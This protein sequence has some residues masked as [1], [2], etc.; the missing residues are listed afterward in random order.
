MGEALGLRRGGARPR[1]QLAAE[2]PARSQMKFVIEALGLTAG[3]GKQLALNLLAG[4]I[5]HEEHEFVLL[6]PN[7]PEYAVLS[8]PNLKRI[9]YEQPPSLGGRYLHLHWT[10]PR[11]CKEERADALLCLG[12]FTPRN[13]PCPTVV[14]IH[15]P[16]L[17]YREP[18]AETHKTFREKLIIAYGRYAL[19]RLSP[20]VR[21]IIQ[22]EVMRQRLVSS[23]KLDPRRVS[24]IPNSYM[25][26]DDV[27]EN[28]APWM[29]GR[30]E[31]FSFLCLTR[32]YTHKNLEILV[33]AV[34]SLSGYRQRAFRCL[35]TISADQHPGAR[36]LINRIAREKLEHVLVNIGPVPSAKLA[37][38][39]RS[40]D[41][42]ILPTLLESFSRTYLEAMHFGLPIL[43]SDRD[44]ARGL[45]QDAAL[46]FDP[47]DA[48]SVA[49]GMRQIM[50]NRE[51]RF[52]LASN[53]K[54]ILEQS[55][56]WDGIA[57]EFV[58]ALER[59][60]GE[61]AAREGSFGQAAGQRNRSSGVLPAEQ[62]KKH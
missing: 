2:I 22:T 39:Y 60:V 52:H 35:I 21:V 27:G 62:V 15:N 48:E 5:K 14:L 7:I 42:L 17:V 4:L 44:F 31:L 49:R 46:Y 36:K 51:L 3:G 9:L 47:L 26:P 10:V 59:A 54:R 13:P 23:Y 30:S 19:R 55:P 32:Y 25:L 45:C 40:A 12:N 61:R 57:A 41:A 53:G 37:E 16:H 28:A 18:V 11:I 38:A 1:P 29:R 24:I 6:L 33:E 43:T 20:R 56:T 34:R 50:E 58:G 8:G